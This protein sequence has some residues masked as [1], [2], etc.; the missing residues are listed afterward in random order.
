[1]PDIPASTPDTWLLRETSACE[2]QPALLSRAL[3]CVTLESRH[4]VNLETG[5]DAHRINRRCDV[6]VSHTTAAAETCRLSCYDDATVAVLP[7]GYLFLIRNMAAGVLENQD[8]D[9]YTTI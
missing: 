1:M 5:A 7:Y 8:W 2:K 3:H 9:G 6:G 4:S